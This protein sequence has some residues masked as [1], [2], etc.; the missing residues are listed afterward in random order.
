M[1]RVSVAAIVYA[2]TEE[3]ATVETAVGGEVDY[4]RGGEP[5]NNDSV[6]GVGGFHGLGFYL[7]VRPTRIRESSMF[8]AEGIRVVA[9]WVRASQRVPQKCAAEGCSRSVLRLRRT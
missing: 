6:Q 1:K 5:A 2:E 7:S 3:P 4:D 8:R 9:E